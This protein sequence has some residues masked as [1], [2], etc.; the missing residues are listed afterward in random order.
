[1]AVEG[2]DDDVVDEVSVD[3]D[4][5]R[6]RQHALRVVGVDRHCLQRTNTSLSLFAFRTMT[7][8]TFDD[9]SGLKMRARAAGTAL[10]A[11]LS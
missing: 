10:A 4:Q 1:M 7:L 6:R 11:L 5:R 8:R 2:G 3:V 9:S